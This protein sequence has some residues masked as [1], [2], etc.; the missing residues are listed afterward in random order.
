[1][2]EMRK[3]GYKPDNSWADMAYRGA[4]L[5]YDKEWG[6]YGLFAQRLFYSACEDENFIIYNEHNSSY[7]QE[8]IDNLREKGVEINYDKK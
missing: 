4:T 6:E 3:R 7:L 1:M 8:C 5:G 2:K